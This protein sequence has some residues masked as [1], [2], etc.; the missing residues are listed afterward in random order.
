MN[1][2]CLV[3]GR[4]PETFVLLTATGLPPAQLRHYA[5]Q[6]GLS[7]D[8]EGFVI[9][10]DEQRDDLRSILEKTGYEITEEFV[11]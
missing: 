11:L 10:T 6:A 9:G 8:D 1:Q 3:W 2:I 5:A 4:L 7:D